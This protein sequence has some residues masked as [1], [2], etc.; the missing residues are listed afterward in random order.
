[1]SMTEE[2][3]VRQIME[4]HVRGD[5]TGAKLVWN[6]ETKMIE[7]ID[8]A[9]SKDPK[10]LDQKLIIEPS[11]MIHFTESNPAPVIILSAENVA[12]HTGAGCFPHA[13]R[14][15]DEGDAYSD[16]HTE[17]AGTAVQGSVCLTASD[18]NTPV[19]ECGRPHDRVRVILNRDSLSNPAAPDRSN[20]NG[21]E[22]PRG[23]VYQREGWIEAAVQFAPIKDDLYSRTRGILETSV[24]ADRCVAVLGL[25]SGGAQIAWEL[26]KLGLRQ[27]LVDG[28]RLEIHNVVRHIGGLSDVGRYKTKIMKERILDINPYAS[29]ETW[30]VMMDASTQDL[31]WEIVEKSDLVIGAVDDHDA[32]MRINRACVELKTPLILAG[33]FRRAYGGQVLYVRPGETPCYQ[34]FTQALPDT[35]RDRE[36]SS[37]RD[38]EGLA[39]TDRP[40]AIEP[41]LSIDIAPISHMVEK[42]TVQNLLQGRPTSLR[43]L[44]EDLTA[45]WFLWL[46]R[47][48]EDTSYEQLKP[49]QCGVNGMSILRW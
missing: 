20:P 33:V 46:N 3:R 13:F 5:Q 11:D 34:C 10:Q 14:C 24:L 30:E 49:L 23:Y 2:E 45:S 21:N 4:N 18:T 43:S 16:I 28:D 40:V 42:L 36:I 37:S 7:T 25:G 48:E 32:R 12:G 17:Q 38:A 47:R 35:V 41:G 31:L 1:M 15:L 9:D 19:D 26:G 27:I 44:D 22:R 39:Y 8:P 29:L 6:P